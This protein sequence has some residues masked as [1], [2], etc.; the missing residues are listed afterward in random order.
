MMLTDFIRL[1]IEAYVN[2]PSDDLLLVISG[3]LYIIP[4]ILAVYY[5]NKYKS[6][7]VGTPF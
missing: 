7:K 4:T 5:Y 6:V 3:F 2:Y 1:V